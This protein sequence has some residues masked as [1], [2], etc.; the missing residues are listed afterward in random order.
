M[1]RG[2]L[3]IVEQMRCITKDSVIIACEMPSY[4]VDVTEAVS[5]GR[6]R[7]ARIVTI[8]DSPAAPICRFADLSFFVSATSPTF[9]SSIIGPIF[10]IHLLTSAL[11]VHL[12]ESAREALEKEASYLHDERFFHPIYG[13]KY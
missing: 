6:D 4:A 5:E 12:G 10:M 8:T 13:L 7:G 2:S 9:G 11:V 1:K 3:S